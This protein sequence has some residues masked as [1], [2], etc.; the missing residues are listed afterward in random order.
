MNLSAEIDTF[1]AELETQCQQIPN[2]ER[3]L[4]AGRSLLAGMRADLAAGHEWPVRT[5]LDVIRESWAGIRERAL[6]WHWAKRGE[7]VATPA[8]VTV[9]ALSV[10]QPWAHAIIHLGKS[11]ENRT[12]S[13]DYRGPLAIH[14]SKSIDGSVSV[15]PDGTKV[16]FE[17]CQI[18]GKVIGIV[19]LVDCRPYSGAPGSVWAECGLICWRLANPR[20][21]REPFDFRG[22]VDL[23]DVPAEGLTC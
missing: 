1:E 13:T 18:R 12:W 17:A 8:P 14:A 7:R 3:Y 21:L 9:K 6:K 4:A 5:L 23:F 15:F 10:K 11:I 19:D 16:P 22:Q 2:G 20:P